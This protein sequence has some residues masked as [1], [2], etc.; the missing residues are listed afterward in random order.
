MRHIAIVHVLHQRPSR[1]RKRRSHRAC[2]SEFDLR[3]R[4][5]PHVDV[6][7]VQEREDRVSQRPHLVW[8]HHTVRHTQQNDRDPVV[9]RRPAR[10]VA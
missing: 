7:S 1:L 4:L 5:V 6:R 10:A 2:A 9:V 3:L 8:R